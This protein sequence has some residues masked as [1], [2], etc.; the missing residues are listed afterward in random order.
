MMRQL[1]SVLFTALLF[2]THV[3]LAQE[4]DAQKSAGEEATEV[5]A[6]VNGQE[7]TAGELE[8]AVD[9]K[10]RLTS[11]HRK[12]SGKELLEL[13]RS[14]GQELVEDAIL[15]QVAE[16]RGTEFSSDYVENKLENDRKRIKYVRVPEEQ[17]LAFLEKRK[18]HYQNKSILNNL[19]RE[20]RGSIETPNEKQLKSYYDNHQEKFM[21]PERFRASVILIKVPA[22]ATSDVRNTFGEQAKFLYSQLQQGASFVDFAREY[23][24]DVTAENGGDMGY[25]HRGMLGKGPQEALDALEPGDISEPLM[26]LDGFIIMKLEDRIEPELLPFNKVKSRV[27]R[28]YRDDQE[29]Q[30]WDNFV[31]KYKKQAS[32]NINEALYERGLEKLDR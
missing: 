31:E 16:K 7:I 5:F 15:L 27:I 26:I 24:D 6:T 4:P 32:I 25:L 3:V 1:S 9:Q 14:V 20:I 11:Y 17:K 28:A 10:L 21:E 18:A 12:P 8:E 22:N 23:S 30:A 13:R 19:E 2:T 29:Q